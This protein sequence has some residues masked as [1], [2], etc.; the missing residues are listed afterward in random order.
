[1][2]VGPR[3]RLFNF[4][5]DYVNWQGCTFWENLSFISNPQHIPILLIHSGKVPSHLFGIGGN[6]RKFKG[7]LFYTK[8]TYCHS[9]G[10][11]EGQNVPQPAQENT[12]GT[13]PSDFVPEQQYKPFELKEA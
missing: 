10:T 13:K 3:V 8:Q 7:I 1:M 2:E 9:W 11:S 4:S 6:K 12:A 5:K